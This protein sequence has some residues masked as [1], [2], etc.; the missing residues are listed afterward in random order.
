MG[1]RN[2]DYTIDFYNHSRRSEP[3]VNR[4]LPYSYYKLGIILYGHS[5]YA[6]D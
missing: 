6:V 5:R 3:R 4:E 2:V 1:G